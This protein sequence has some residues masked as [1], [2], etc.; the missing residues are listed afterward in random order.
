MKD[1]YY[2]FSEDTADY[3]EPPMVKSG[4]E[5]VQFATEEYKE[6]LFETLRKL[7]TEEQGCDPY[8]A[9]KRVLIKWP[10]AQEE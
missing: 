10:Q 9:D 1:I 5:V 6:R 3:M 8:G 4:I 2:V 7:L